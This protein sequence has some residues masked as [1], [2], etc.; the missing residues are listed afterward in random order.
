MTQHNPYHTI[1][2][3][4]RFVKIIFAFV[5]TSWC[6][7][8]SGQKTDKVTLKNGDTI[9]GEIM[10]MK[11]GKLLYDVDG[12]GKINIKWEKVTGVT[13]DKIFE[14]TLRGGV[15]V[16][17]R[18]DS[19][20]IMHQISSLDDI[21]EIIPIKDRFLTRLIGD[22]TLGLNYTKSNSTLQFNF[23]SNVSY[24]IPKLEL[25]LK[26]NSVLTSD[27]RDSSLAKKQDAVFG[28]IRD[29]AKKFFWGGS[30]G[31]QQN[32]EL[33]LANR[34]LVSG[35]FGLKA[36]ADNHNQLSFSGGLSYNQEQSIETSQ[37]TGNLDALFGAQYKRFYLST[38]KLSID[39]DYY[40]YPGI[41][42]WGRIRMQGDLNFS[43]EIVKDFE[44]GLVFYYSY[45]NRP[46]AGSLSNDDYGLMFTLCYKFGK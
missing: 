39:A 36:I 11:L 14:F 46:P 41:S 8:A 24:K 21:V 40:L 25:T 18:L 29:M 37:Y 17:T 26:L 22:I 44:I 4:S 43:V 42:D 45:D 9:T 31:W 13:S 19:L 28:L 7:V 32:T 2:S 3:F 6:M 33:G 30:T 12:P 38:P 16:T 23:S 1:I 15:L 35:V 34:F 20:F 5:L 27:G 10:N